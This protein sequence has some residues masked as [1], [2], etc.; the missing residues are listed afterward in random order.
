M[1]TREVT[2]K[3][4]SQIQEVLLYSLKF[5]FSSC[6]VSPIVEFDVVQFLSLVQ[7]F[8]TPWTAAHQTLSSTL[9]LSLLKLMSFESVMLS[10]HL[11]LCCPLLLLPSSFPQHQLVNY[12]ETTPIKIN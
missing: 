4:S 6:Q 9:S 3:W 5:I 10:N 11:I 7:L 12:R 1:N 2:N 8:S